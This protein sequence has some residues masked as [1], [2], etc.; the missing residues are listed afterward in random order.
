MQ[1]ANSL[2]DSSLPDFGFQNPQPMEELML[3]LLVGKKGSALERNKKEDG[4]DDDG[5]EKDEMPG[6]NLGAFR[7]IGSLNIHNIL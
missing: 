3:G 2:Q 6:P 4:D 1:R 5:K 7:N